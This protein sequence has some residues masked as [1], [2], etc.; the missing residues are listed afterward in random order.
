MSINNKIYPSSFKAAA[1]IA[2]GLLFLLPQIILANTN[3]IIVSP[4]GD[5]EVVVGGGINIY[6]TA[7]DPVISG[8]QFSS[9]D[10]PTFAEIINDGHNSGHISVNTSAGQ[11]GEYLFH[12]TVSGSAGT[13][14]VPV[15]LRVLAIN[16]DSKVYY[17][18][19]VNGSMS[20]TGDF[21]NPWGTLQQVF[22]SSK[23]FEEGDVVFLRDGFH[24]KPEILGQNSGKVYIAAQANHS[25]KVRSL[26]FVFAKN[27]VVSGL[28]ISPETA[29][30]YEKGDYLKLIANAKYNVVENCHIFGI[31]NGDTWD[32][33]QD[34]YDNAG[35]GVLNKGEFN[36]IRNNLITNTNF[37]A[38]IDSENNHFDYNIIDRFSGDAI[39]CIDSNNSINY[40]VV[41]N[42]VVDDYNDP[43]GNHDDAFQSWTFGN[44]VRNIVI[45][46]NVVFSCTDP[47]LILK[48][49]VMQGIVIFD[50]FAED[51]VVENNLVVQDHPHGI[52]LYGAKNCKVVNNTVI[53]NPLQ[54]FFFGA[55]PWV[56]VNKHKDGRFST[57]NL[58][59]NN[60]SGDIYLDAVPGTDDHNTVSS[61]YTANLADYDNW[62]FHLKPDAFAIDK[63]F[64]DDSPQIDNE[65]NVRLPSNIP[66]R[67]CFEKEANIFDVTPPTPPTNVQI[68][69]TTVSSVVLAWDAAT[70]NTGV[71]HYR[72]SYEGGSVNTVDNEAYI[73]GLKD[74]FDYIFNVTA[75][76]YSGNVSPIETIAETT[77]AIPSDGLYNIKISAHTDDQQIRSNN[78][79]E[80]VGL[81]EYHIGGVTSDY[82]TSVVIPFKLPLIGD[83]EEIKSAELKFN[84]KEIKNF[85]QG[86]IDIY[87][88][89]YSTRSDVGPGD[90]W[91]GNFN[92]DPNSTGLVQNFISAFS[93]PGETHMDS[94]ATIAIADYIKAQY[95]QGASPGNY[96]FFRLNVGVP[97]EA[98]GNYY[99]LNS[100]DSPRSVDRPYMELTVEAGVTATDE[101]TSNIPELK[102]YPNPIGSNDFLNIEIPAAAHGN[103]DLR[104]HDYLGRLVY[105]QHIAAPSRIFD[106]NLKSLKLISGT[107]QLSLKENSFFAQAKIMVLNGY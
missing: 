2:I 75:I 25:P 99:I 71:S 14:V 77:P 81:H 11:E 52:A 50:G 42:A 79:L 59:R 7:F 66:D 100:A 9:D 58:V 72:V 102:I 88:L 30:L 28:D 39:R 78:K 67:G 56:R 90:H 104:I 19:P 4:I 1:L 33:K 47:D 24:G 18:D 94:A 60:I 43:G 73:Y 96:I 32:I 21:D 105:Q 44:P 55:Q 54:L 38:T 13:S 93:S 40:N 98:D 45:R 36:T 91:Q 10:L 5:Q 22:A 3:T 84:L 65:R 20:N 107:Y 49:S 6:F 63:G 101:K 68:L 103:M 74:G 62:D 15:H 17:C 64:I 70:D 82:N 86:S 41:M 46:G 16:P 37:S 95:A 85:P 51:W 48:T 92:T 87:G 80:W 34:W 29:G 106:L 97:S 23:T 12:L 61:F 57:G 26:K 76:D 8:A 69:E 31:Q 83:M 27:W 35:N 89:G 53:R